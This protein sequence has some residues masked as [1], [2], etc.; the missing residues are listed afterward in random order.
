MQVQYFPYSLEFKYPFKIAH[1]NRTH[2]NVVY[3]KVTDGGAVGWGESAYPPYLPENQESF[4]AL[5]KLISWPQTIESRDQLNEFLTQLKLQFPQYIT[6]IAAIDMALHQLWANKNGVS[7]PQVF[8]LE[9]SNKESSFTIGIGSKA[10]MEAKM[11]DQKE[12][13]YYKLKIDQEHFKRIFQDYSDLSDLPFVVDAN[14]GFSNRKEALYCADYLKE[15]G[16]AY[17]EQPFH[18]EDFD[19]HRWLSAHCSIPIIADESFQRVSDLEKVR[20]A[21]SGFNVKLAKCGGL[22]EA[23][24]ALMRSKKLDLLAILGCMS[25]SSVAINAAASLKSLADFVDLDGPLLIKNDPD[26]SQFR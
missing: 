6:S 5:V 23:Y 26:L 20:K 10:E 19:S 3:V 9:A 11:A 15:R 13:R 7:L 1:T 21:F 22:Q 18:K 8:G 4:S 2:T 17:L 25:E 14:Q 24:D 12:V 16:V